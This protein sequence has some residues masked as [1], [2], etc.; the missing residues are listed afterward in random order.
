MDHDTH[1]LFK[2]V[3]A[4]LGWNG[5]GGLDSAKE[6]LVRS[7]GKVRHP[8]TEDSNGSLASADTQKL[9]RS[10]RSG[11][12]NRQG[13]G[14]R[15]QN[16]V[17]LDSSE[18]DF[19]QFLLEKATPNP[20]VQRLLTRPQSDG[21]SIHLV[22]SGSDSSFEEF[23]NRVKT[24][25]SKPAVS[26]RSGSD[27]SLKQFIV[28]SCSSDDD[29]ITQRKKKPAAKSKRKTP[30]SL[31]VL[32]PARLPPHQWESP[33]FLS[34]SDQDEGVVMRSTWKSR[35][36]TRGP[37][38]AG[39]EGGASACVQ[40]A[41]STTP[42]PSSKTTSSLAQPPS[43]KTPSSLAPPPSSKTPSYLAPPSSLTAPSSSTNP[44]KE[45]HRAPPPMDNSASSEEEFLSLLDR[46]KRNHGTPRPSSVPEPKQKPSL[47]VPPGRDLGG[48]GPPKVEKGVRRDGT[49]E[50][51]TGTLPHVSLTEP[52]PASR[53]RVAVCKTPG[54][55]LESLSG[56]ASLYCRSFR[57]NKGELASRLYKLFNS[58]VFDDKLPSDMSVSWNKKMRKTAGFCITGQHREGGKRYA[59][60][61]LSDKVCDSADRL[62]DT[63]IHEMCHAAVWLIN[64]VRDGHG[65]FW[66]LYARK[67]TL[68][69]PELP[70]VTRC[71]SY[72]I[73]YKYQYQCSRCKNTIGRHSKS[74][75]T[76][77]FVCALCQGKLVLLT[78][79]KPRAA[80]PF[81][82][83][84]KENYGAVR[85]ELEGQSHADVMRKLSADFALKTRLSES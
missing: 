15:R 52:R 32:K 10:G 50:Q 4:K 54:C 34:D 33:V 16:R 41:S 60:I 83:F 84:V 28:D 58:T 25:K 79:A 30:S 11:K 74:L 80:T 19:E 36:T 20:A 65:P 78:P 13:D 7:T 61:E 51:L 23:L 70:M 1:S 46:L 43:S 71:H 85:Q 57:Q 76:G 5:P 73:N 68:A 12:E 24:P 42:P 9:S 48:A 47:S 62:R 14:E 8:L 18:D 44:L 6:E 69:H 38:S 59:R 67:A 64:G 21:P 63:L 39:Q 27:D 66:K 2:R 45:V 49:P 26:V 40:P 53:T 3:V 37:G 55:F 29:F 31:Q 35:H 22:S 75:D 56:P 82:N 17:H 72:D 77:R 81:A